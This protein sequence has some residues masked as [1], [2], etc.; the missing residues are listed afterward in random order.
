MRGHL[1]ADR[2]LLEV[3]LDACDEALDRLAFRGVL[4][5]AGARGSGPLHEQC[6]RAS[7]L[8]TREQPLVRLEALSDALAVVEAVRAK[9]DLSP[10]AVLLERVGRVP[11]CGS[12]HP[13]RIDADRVR[14]DVRVWRDPSQ[15]ARVALRLHCDEVVLA[16]RL[17]D[18]LRARYALPP[19]L[20]HGDVVE[21]AEGARPAEGTK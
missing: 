2:R 20:V 8:R 3:P 15:D 11:G 6:A 7:S 12:A 19:V 1:V 14:L 10:G 9:Q 16:E 5:D 13:I 17:G 4:G 21:V 18:G